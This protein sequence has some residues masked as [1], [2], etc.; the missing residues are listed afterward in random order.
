MFSVLAPAAPLAYI[1]PQLG[2]K[3]LNLFHDIGGN[4]YRGVASFSMSLAVS[5]LASTMGGIAG[6]IAQGFLH[7][8]LDLI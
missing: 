8:A 2:G 4:L 1:R 3:L 7:T 6:K 5:S